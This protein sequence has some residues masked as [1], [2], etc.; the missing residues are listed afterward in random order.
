VLSL[1][2]LQITEGDICFPDSC[3]STKHYYEN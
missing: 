3:H 1:V 2:E